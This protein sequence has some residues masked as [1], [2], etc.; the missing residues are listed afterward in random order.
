[1]EETPSPKRSQTTTEESRSPKRPKTTTEESRDFPL[2]DPDL[3]SEPNV[4]QMDLDKSGPSSIQNISIFTIPEK[5]QGSQL[6]DYFLSVESSIKRFGISCTL[7]QV[8]RTITLSKTDPDNIYE[9]KPGPALNKN[10]CFVMTSYTNYFHQKRA[11]ILQEAWP[12]VESLLEHL[13]ISSTLNMVECSMTVSTTRRT[14]DPYVIDEACSLLELLCR[15]HVPPSMAIETLSGSRKHTL[16]KMGNEEG[17]LC[18]KFEIKKEEYRKRWEF[19]SHS[20]M[21]LAETTRCHLFL[22]KDSITAVTAVEDSSTGLHVLREK[23]ENCFTSSVDDLEDPHVKHMEMENEDDMLEVSFLYSL[24][25]EKRAKKLQEAW[26]MVESS[27]KERGIYYTWNEAE[28]S[29]TFSTTRRTNEPY[30]IDKAWHLLELLSTTHVPTSMAIEVMNGS[31]QH[32]HIK[33][34]NQQGGLC[35]KFRIDKEEYLK[36]WNCLRFSLQALS[37]LA[38]CNLFLNETTVTAVGNSLAVSAVRAFVED[39]ILFNVCPAIAAQY[40]TIFLKMNRPM[41]NIE[42]LHDCHMMEKSDGILEVTCLYR[43]YDDEEKLEED[44]KMLEFCFKEHH[45]S[46]TVI[47]VDDTCMTVSTSRVTG[48]SDI[49]EKA[50]DLL[51][52]LSATC[53]PAPMAMKVLEGNLHYVFIKTGNEDGGLCSKYGIKEEQFVQLRQRLE[54]CLKV[55]KVI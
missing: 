8:D 23:V 41:E 20:L 5:I 26:P 48:E 4:D 38:C 36:R 42:N 25:D 17:G 32:Y 53:V 43:V 27:L 29:L 46:D 35:S 33:I 30:V 44:R 55:N 49:I 7:N 9:E 45:I 31:M 54:N 21:A 37:E 18:S 40:I 50:W 11:T 6:D 1:M 28:N 13:G 3:P 34:R 52:L 10:G 24:L 12:M 39:C 51:E 14:V 22:N 19:L 15:T 16:I 2:R 47:Q